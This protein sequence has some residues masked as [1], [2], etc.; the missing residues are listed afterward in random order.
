MRKMQTLVNRNEQ[1]AANGL[2]EL[3]LWNVYSPW[4]ECL[5]HTLLRVGM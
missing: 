4:D 3:E 2:A 5:T 1:Q